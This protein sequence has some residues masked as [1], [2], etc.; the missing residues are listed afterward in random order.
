MLLLVLLLALYVAV[1]EAGIPVPPTSVPGLSA[2][3]DTPA[4]ATV[5]SISKSMFQGDPLNSQYH[6]SWVSPTAGVVTTMFAVQCTVRTPIS[7]SNQAYRH[8]CVGVYP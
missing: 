8:V 4:S 7:H 3:W 2:P 6:A 1:S 5:F